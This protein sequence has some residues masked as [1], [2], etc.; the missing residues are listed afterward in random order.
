MTQI[1]VKESRRSGGAQ[2]STPVR[3]VLYEPGS[4]IFSQSQ[5][6]SNFAISKKLALEAIIPN[7]PPYQIFTSKESDSYLSLIESTSTT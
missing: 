5:V 4:E 1:I 2:D 3:G 6:Q 7:T